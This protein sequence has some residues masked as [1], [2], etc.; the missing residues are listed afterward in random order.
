MTIAP[1]PPPPLAAPSTAADALVDELYAARTVPLADGG[2]APMDVYIPREEGEL[3]YALVRSLR[4]ELSIEVGMAN[5][6]STLFIAKA[7]R[8]NAAG[9]HIA[10]DPF[11]STHWRGAGLALLRRARLDSLV[12]LRELPS[13]QALPELERSGLRAQFA[14]VDGA[15]LFDY[16]IADF[17]CI[18]RF[19]DIGGL[20]AF[21][22]ADWPAVRQAIR[23]V[24]ANRA[25]EV[26]TVDVPIED[27]PPTPTAAARAVRAVARAV[28]PLGRKLR[29][30]FLNPDED[31]GLRGRCVVLRK[32]AEESRDSQSRCHNPF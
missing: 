29:A 30:D 2:S 10:I 8:D 12:E 1:A 4:P 6:L 3:L 20:I 32:L 9:R 11:Q 17:L 22:D 15:H 13:H 21:D 18:D 26:A 16:V 19:L 28:P 7:L 14:F 31:L 24:L 27:R 5:G 23:Y 25:Y